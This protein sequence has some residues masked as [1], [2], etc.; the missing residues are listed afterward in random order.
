M[1]P[2][3]HHGT[4]PPCTEAVLAAGVSKVVA[5]SLD[6]NPE[7]GGGLELLRE[8]GVEVELEDTF[9]G[10]RAERSLANLDRAG[11]ARS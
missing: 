2:C 4:T 11:S 5:G 1:E 3:A 10:A 7:A 6:P 9:D 8:Q